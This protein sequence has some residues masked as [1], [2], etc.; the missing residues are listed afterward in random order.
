MHLSNFVFLVCSDG[1]GPI[2]VPQQRKNKEKG[3]RLITERDKIKFVY[4]GF[5]RW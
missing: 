1:L 5:E 2:T 3:E 4:V